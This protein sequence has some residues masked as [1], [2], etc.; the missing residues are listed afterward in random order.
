MHS[1]THRICSYLSYVVVC[2]S[3][4]GVLCNDVMCFPAGLH[5]SAMYVWV[6]SQKTGFS[7]T[8]WEESIFNLIM[9]ITYC[10]CFFNLRVSAEPSY[11]S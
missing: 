11:K 2:A 7:A 6:V 4:A 9:A 8:Q 3:L 10:F 1:N 5:L